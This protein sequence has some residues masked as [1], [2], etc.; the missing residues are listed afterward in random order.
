MQRGPV[1]VRCG[2]LLFALFA[3]MLPDWTSVQDRP[4]SVRRGVHVAA[5]ASL[6][7]Q[8]RHLLS[9]PERMRLDVL[10]ASGADLLSQRSRPL[11]CETTTLRHKLR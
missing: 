1:E 4:V 7:Q 9:G 10:L 2:H 6:L 8:C 11:R 5:N 3:D